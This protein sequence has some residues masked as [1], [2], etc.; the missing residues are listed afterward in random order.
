M[1]RITRENARQNLQNALDS[2]AKVIGELI[3]VIFTWDGKMNAIGTEP[4]KKFAVR[5]NPKYIKL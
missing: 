5:T 2:F 4:I 1:P 3:G